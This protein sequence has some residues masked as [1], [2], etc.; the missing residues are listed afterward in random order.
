MAGPGSVLTLARNHE[1]CQVVKYY[2]VQ[3]LKQMKSLPT[4]Q[5][6]FLPTHRKGGDQQSV[7]SRNL[8]LWSLYTLSRL[9][10]GGG[11]RGT[12]PP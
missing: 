11:P 2:N 6:L 7:I 12:C 5:L 10:S 3:I 1:M 8:Y 9:G 4:F